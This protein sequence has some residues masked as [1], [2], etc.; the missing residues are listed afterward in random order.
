VQDLPEPVIAE[1]LDFAEFLRSKMHNKPVNSGD[2][3]L[4][5]LMGGLENPVTFEGE[6]LEIQKRLRDEWQ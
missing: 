1:P 4:I 6:F 3:L 5:D 2:E